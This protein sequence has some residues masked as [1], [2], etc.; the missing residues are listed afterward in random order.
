VKGGLILGP[1]VPVALGAL[2][3]AIVRRSP[4]WLLVVAAAGA[5]E[6]TPPYR[7]RLRRK[8]DLAGD[9]DFKSDTFPLQR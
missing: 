1:A 8:A 6:L 5:I 3:L 4:G 2:G 7:A 9:A